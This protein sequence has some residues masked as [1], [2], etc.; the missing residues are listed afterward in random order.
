M[1]AAY[2]KEQGAQI[3]AHVDAYAELE[4][5]GERILGRV[6]RRSRDKGMSTRLVLPDETLTER[7]LIQL[8]D[9]R[10]ELLHLG[11]AHSPGDISVWLPQQKLVIA[12]DIAFH[13]RSRSAS[14]PRPVDEII[15]ANRGAPRTGQA[16]VRPREKQRKPVLPASSA[17]TQGKAGTCPGSSRMR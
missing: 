11:P 9:R 16:L 14:L 15:Q 4:A 6:L 7:K 5:H 3:I 10:I 1:G 17:R 8:G 13:Q 2:W 12:G